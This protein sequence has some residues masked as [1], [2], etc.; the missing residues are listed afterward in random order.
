MPHEKKDT[1]NGFL[2]ASLS[3]SLSLSLSRDLSISLAIGWSQLWTRVEGRKREKR[4]IRRR[5]KSDVKSLSQNVWTIIPYLGHQSGW[6][7]TSNVLKQV[8]PSLCCVKSFAHKRLAWRY[9]CKLLQ[10]IFLHVHFL[11]DCKESRDLLFLEWFLIYS[12]KSRPRKLQC[13]PLLAFVSTPTFSWS[14]ASVLWGQ[15]YGGVDWINT[16]WVTRCDLYEPR[17]LHG[18]HRHWYT[19]GTVPTHVSTRIA[20]DA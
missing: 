1:V 14:V 13:Q 2:S 9:I 11:S 8:T 4:I 17:P 20:I 18:L 6:P 7:S 15:Y 19:A 16:K 5:Y 10:V 3:L 12:Y